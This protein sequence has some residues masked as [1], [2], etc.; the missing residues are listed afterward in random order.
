MIGIDKEL[1]HTQKPNLLL[2]MLAKMST[3]FVN[4]FMDT[5]CVLQGIALRE[6]QKTT[7]VLSHPSERW[8]TFRLSSFPTTTHIFQQIIVQAK[9]WDARNEKEHTVANICLWVV[10]SKYYQRHRAGPPQPEI[11]GRDRSDLKF[12]FFEY[13]FNRGIVRRKYKDVQAGIH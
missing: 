5:E 8:R 3:R 9:K 13:D 2:S 4:V 11:K 1:I 12:S 7:V 6:N 10:M